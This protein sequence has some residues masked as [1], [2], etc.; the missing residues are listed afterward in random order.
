MGTIYDTA[1]WRTRWKLTQS[2]RNKA[3]FFAPFRYVCAVSTVVEIEAAM[4]HLSAE[5]LRR[6]RDWLLSH[7][8]LSGV[9]RPKTGAELAR[10]WPHLPHLPAGEADALAA[11]LNEVRARQSPPRSPAWE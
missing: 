11:D 7:P 9:T 6:L 5:E 10:I 2:V 4:E 1:P 3:C 8:V